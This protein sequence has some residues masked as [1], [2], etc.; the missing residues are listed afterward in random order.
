MGPQAQTA[1]PVR[2]LHTDAGGW[3]RAAGSPCPSPGS[4]TGCRPVPHAPARH[5]DATR[6]S[7][8]VRCA[9]SFLAH[10]SLFMKR[11]RNCFLP[12]IKLK[13]MKCWL[14]KGMAQLVSFNPNIKCPPNPK[15]GCPLLQESLSRWQRQKRP[16]P[17]LWVDE[18][19]LGTLTRFHP[20]SIAP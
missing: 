11:A 9:S 10:L 3:P 2:G 8:L 16:A 7:E 13:L 15:E 5:Q 19:G 20:S 6:A 17:A 12:N 18:Q 4:P 14:F 1:Q